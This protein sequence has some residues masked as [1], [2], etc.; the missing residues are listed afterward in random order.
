M[1][2]PVVLALVAVLVFTGLTEALSRALSVRNTSQS[3]DLGFVA[4]E[5]CPPPIDS[6]LL[7]GGGKTFLAT[8]TGKKPRTLL[9]MS[10]STKSNM[11]GSAAY[12]T[13]EE[14]SAIVTMGRTW[15][16][17]SGCRAPVVDAWFV[18]G[19][20][21]VESQSTLVMIN[22]SASA[23]TAEVTAWTPTG[24]SAAS[25]L[26]VPPLGTAQ[27][28]L[29]RFAAA[30]IVTRVRALSGRLGL[31]LLD[32]R[33]RG[34]TQLGG[35]YVAAQ[36]TPEK[37]QVIVGVPSQSASRL[38]LLVPGNQ[39]AV[40]RVDLA[41]GSD[42]F[43]PAGLDALQVK[44]G[45]VVE[46]PLV[47]A[48]AG[49]GAKIFGTVVIDS[50]VPILAGIYSPFANEGKK[51]VDFAWLA[52]S[53]PLTAPALA[54]AGPASSLLVFNQDFFD[55]SRPTL[56]TSTEI[57]G[58]SVADIAVDQI[59]AISLPKSLRLSSNPRLYVAQ[60]VRTKTGFSVIPLNPL[61]RTAKRVAPVL[62]L[63]V[64]IPR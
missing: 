1:R 30:A 51:Q 26:S 4:P 15:V 22:Q 21:V 6:A 32:R 31:Y 18:G 43:T 48:K 55:A 57:S 2:R 20:G 12:I 41:F 44:A 49:L 47:S 39:D 35:D 7:T 5:I 60:M 14:Q 53:Q 37:R 63:R 40:I 11:I 17:A 54:L 62:D 56:M 9:K 50:D 8:T 58:K 19:S 10:T 34:L 46:L 16:A 64:L 13:G 59:K 36:S 33:S 42:R 27:I 29:D 52:P 45:T 38:R 28:S 24:P 25:T 3:I 61:E 23:A